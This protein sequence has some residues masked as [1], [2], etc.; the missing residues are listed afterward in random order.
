MKDEVELKQDE[1]LD[2]KAGDSLHGVTHVPVT[3]DEVL[4]SDGD[5][6]WKWMKVGRTELS[7]PFLRQKTKN[8]VAKLGQFMELPSKEVSRLDLTSTRSESWLAVT[9]LL[10][11]TAAFPPVILTQRCFP[12][13]CHGLLV[14]LTVLS[15]YLV[16]VC[17]FT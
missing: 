9:T 11:P 14:L 13:S 3:A 17:F 15:L 16:M 1:L 12:I 7:L 4:A 8:F 5:E 2:K 10:T 6:E